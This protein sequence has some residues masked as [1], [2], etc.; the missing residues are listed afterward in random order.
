[1]KSCDLHALPS[2]LEGTPRVITEA[3]A[4]GVPCAV[5]D[6]GDSAEIVGATGR[7]VPP[8]DPRALAAAMREMLDMDPSKRRDLGALA[9]ER[10]ARH[11]A[12]PAVTRRYEALWEEVA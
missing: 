6:I 4:C 5:T 7:V 3:M 12:L 2:R 10:V 11:Y 9:R 1:M 8:R